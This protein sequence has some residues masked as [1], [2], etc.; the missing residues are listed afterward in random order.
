MIL[1]NDCYIKHNCGKFKRGE[2]AIDTYCTRLFKLNYL[3]DNSLLSNKQRVHQDIYIDSDGTDSIA[4]QHLKEIQ[5]NIV[6]FVNDGNNIYLYSSICGNGK[7]SWSIRMMQAYF[8]NIWHSTDLRCRGLFINVPRFLL[9]LKSSIS[10]QSD[11]IDLIKDN[12]ETAD[13]VIWDDIATKSATEFE[14]ENLLS[15]IDNRLNNNKCNIFTSN[16]NPVQLKSQLGDRLTSR[17]VNLSLN[18]EL[19]GKDKRVLSK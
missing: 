9:A 12:I 4:F 8:N 11:Y 16:L 1:S 2:C 13:I 14:H 19:R 15:M 7:T 3:Y 5:N 17:I 6:S 10:E 18:I